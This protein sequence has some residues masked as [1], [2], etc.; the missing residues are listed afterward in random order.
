MYVN[1]TQIIEDVPYERKDIFIPSLD[2]H[3]KNAFPFPSR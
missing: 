1:K 3:G 2:K